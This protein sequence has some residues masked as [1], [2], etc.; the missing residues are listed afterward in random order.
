MGQEFGLRSGQL[1]LAT[2]D[3]EHRLRLGLTKQYDSIN[4]ARLDSVGGACNCG[5]RHQNA[6]AI[7]L[8]GSFQTGRQIYGVTH[9]SVAHHQL[10]AD[11]ADE[12]LPCRNADAYVE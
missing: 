10:G 12:R 2:H 1:A 3:L 8:V 7:H 11:A 5:L 4:F 6:T 9:D